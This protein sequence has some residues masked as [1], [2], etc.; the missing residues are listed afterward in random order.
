[1]AE[2]IAQLRFE[3]R[4]ALEVQLDPKS[5][6]MYLKQ[7]WGNDIDNRSKKHFN[8][9][10][11]FANDPTSTLTLSDTSGVGN[12]HSRRHERY[13]LGHYTVRPKHLTTRRDKQLVALRLTHRNDRKAF[14]VI[15]KGIQHRIPV[16]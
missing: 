6:S 1:L 5:G 8:E 9:I 16:S 14:K 7:F 13:R 12:A 3:R 2:G 15:S 10:L 4:V 11:K